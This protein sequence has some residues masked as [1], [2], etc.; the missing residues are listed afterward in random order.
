MKKFIALMLA[1][2]LVFALSTAAFAAVTESGGSDSATVYATYAAGSAAQTVY[3]VDIAWGSMEFTYTGATEGAWSTTSHDYENAKEAAWSCTEGANVVTVT[4][5]S[6]APISATL[7]YT[8]NDG[9]AGIK[10]VFDQDTLS[11]KSAVGTS[12]NE[13]PT[14]TTTLTLTGALDSATADKVTIGTVKITITGAAS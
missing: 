2:A 6:N 7:D 9:Y 13:A 10:G 3:S 12:P 8:A 5:H 1:I 4:N 14:A 11:L